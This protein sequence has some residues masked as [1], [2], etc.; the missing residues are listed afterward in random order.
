MCLVI[1]IFAD[2][3]FYSR[4]TV[5]GPSIFKCLLLLVVFFDAT[6]WLLRD[7]SRFSKVQKSTARLQQLL[8]KASYEL[9]GRY[10]TAQSKN[11]SFAV[12]FN[13]A[14]LLAEP[15]GEPLLNNV[16]ISFARGSLSLVT[17]NEKRRTLLQAAIGN[18]T[19]SEGIVQ[20]G[21]SSIS[22]CGSDIWIQRKSIKE[23]IIGGRRFQQTWYQQ[24]IQACCLEEVIDRL[25]GN[26]E[27]IVETSSTRLNLSQLQRVALARSV[28]S[29]ADMI[30]LD[31]IFSHQDAATSATIRHN[32]FFHDGLLR[33]NT[34]VLI[35]T[36]DWQSF[37][38]MAAQFISIENGQV[39]RT[40]QESLLA[41]L[42]AETALQTDA[43]ITKQ[44][45]RDVFAGSANQ[46][47]IRDLL[48]NMR[49]E[50]P[51]ANKIEG[52]RFI[53]YLGRDGV[54]T[55]CFALIVIIVFLALENI[56]CKDILIN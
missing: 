11:P 47:M 13:N 55:F 38:N 22:Y 50:E 40:N 43:D 21:S 41:R 4:P 9:D 23:N 14:T 35:A 46:L 16:N 49:N 51:I 33:H 1:Y 27:Y 52:A 24:V 31:D 28:Y 44:L 53:K 19:I 2:D 39:S 48:S 7:I 10:I 8:E 18:C 56:E 36:E 29:G 17:G 15:G 37:V 34:T 54:L 6:S 32:L 12:Q 42:T 5:S 45:K 20:I 3:L 26:S 30:I 25:P